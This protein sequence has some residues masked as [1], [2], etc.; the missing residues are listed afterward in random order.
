MPMGY[1]DPYEKKLQHCLEYFIHFLRKLSAFKNPGRYGMKNALHLIYKLSEL[2]N[3]TC[4][5]SLETRSLYTKWSVFFHS[6]WPGAACIADGP[7]PR[8]FRNRT[9]ALSARD[10]HLPSKQLNKRN[11]LLTYVCAVGHSLQG[12]SVLYLLVDLQLF[13]SQIWILIKNSYKS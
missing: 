9:H 3:P 1:L 8:W 10:T 7:D 5:S 13:G 12:V 6:V 2:F 4:V 11:R